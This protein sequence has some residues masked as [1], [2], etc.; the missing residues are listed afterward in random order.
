MYMQICVLNTQKHP[1]LCKFPARWWSSSD[2]LSDQ[3]FK[4]L[5]PK[6][7]V[8]CSVLA[9]CLNCFRVCVYMVCVGCEWYMYILLCGYVNVCP[10]VWKCMWRS[11]V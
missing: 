2:L 9:V 3:D 8:G 4:E 5:A 1:D 11:V 10:C 7:G 6:A